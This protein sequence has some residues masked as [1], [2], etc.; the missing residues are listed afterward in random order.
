M[1]AHEAGS[2]DQSITHTDAVCRDFQIFESNPLN[3]P[4]IRRE[5]EN[6]ELE[7]LRNRRVAVAS[8]CAVTDYPG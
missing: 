3:D 4:G 8:P 2:H 1:D 6:C 5:D 7:F